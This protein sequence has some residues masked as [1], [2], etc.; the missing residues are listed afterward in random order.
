MDLMI[1]FSVRIDELNLPGSNTILGRVLV[2]VDNDWG[3]VC[4]RTFTDTEAAVVCRQLGFQY[5][6]SLHPSHFSG[7]VYY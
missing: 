7:Y 5:S 3:A 4:A 2:Y 1:S 6:K